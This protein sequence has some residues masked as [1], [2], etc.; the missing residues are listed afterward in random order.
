MLFLLS[1]SSSSLLS[2]SSSSLSLLL[3]SFSKYYSIPM[4]HKLCRSFHPW[5]PGV[6]TRCLSVLWL[7]CLS[8][9]GVVC[10]LLRMHNDFVWHLVYWYLQ[11]LYIWFSLDHLN[12]PCGLCVLMH[13]IVFFCWIWTAPYVVFFWPAHH[14]GLLG[15]NFFGQPGSVSKFSPFFVG[16]I[17]VGVGGEGI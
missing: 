1:S 4:R 15:C 3:L 16:K 17:V 14:A 12:A 6:K 2:S 10:I 5:C 11:C 9:S 7:D 8:R 13:L